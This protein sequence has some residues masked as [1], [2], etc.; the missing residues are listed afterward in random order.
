MLCH[1]PNKVNDQRVSRFEVPTT[2]ANSVNFKV[3][4]HKIH[5]GD[6]LAQRLRA[7]RLPRA[8]RGQPGGTPVDFG[9]VAFPGNLKACW[10]CHAGTSYLLPLPSGLLPTKTCADAPVQRRDARRRTRTARTAAFRAESFLARSAR[11]ARRATTRASTVAHAQIMT[12]P[13]GGESCETCHGSGKQWDVQ[14][15]HTLPP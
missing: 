12:A 6:Q 13:N 10:A 2:V 15:V 11:R 3:M 1:T 8:D 4:V 9:T 5:R 7:R 14:A